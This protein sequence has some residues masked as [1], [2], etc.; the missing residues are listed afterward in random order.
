MTKP[1][2]EFSANEGDYSIG[3]SGPDA[4]EKDIDTLARMFDPLTTHDGGLPGG[5]GTENIQNNALTDSLIGDRTIN[6]V[7]PDAYINTGKLSLLFSLIAKAIKAIKGTATWFDNP[8]DTINNIHTRVTTNTTNMTNHKAS[9]DHDTKYYTKVLI[10]GGQLDNRYFT[11]AELNNGQL[12]GRYFTE[13]EINAKVALLATKIEN[14][15]K[16]N[17][18]EVFTKDQLNANQLGTIYYTK[19][20]L[21]PWLGGGDTN[22]KEE[23]FTIVN[24]NNGDGTFNYSDGVDN[25]LGTLTPEGYQIFTLTKGYYELDTSRIEA[26]INDTLRR[27]VISGGL[28]EIDITH[29]ALTSPE[30]T[31]A[32]ITFKYYERIAMAGEY[33]VRMGDV[34]P[35]GNNGKNMWFEVIG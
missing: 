21:I 17:A 6:D 20:E 10:D 32:E 15:L 19:T 30:G 3:L 16:A 11:E 35:L 24:S 22:V 34:K 5:I 14:D 4:I 12:D 18:S 1:V 13:A 28:Q 25:I 8:S 33:N 9:N 29:I 27:S 26:T 2:R 23:V 31:G 7:I